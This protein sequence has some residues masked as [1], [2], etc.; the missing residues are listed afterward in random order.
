[1]VSGS[2]HPSNVVVHLGP[3][4]SRDAVQIS[5]VRHRSVFPIAPGLPVVLTVPYRADRKRWPAL[6]SQACCGATLLPNGDSIHRQMSDVQA[7]HEPPFR[8][9]RICLVHIAR[10]RGARKRATARKGSSNTK[11]GHQL[12]G[13]MNSDACASLDPLTRPGP[14]RR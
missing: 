8:T 12:V 4:R 2:R 3:L 6:H 9:A 10:V 5:L 11:F 7:R 14:C 13:H 1:M